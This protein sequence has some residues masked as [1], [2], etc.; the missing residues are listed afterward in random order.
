MEEKKKEKNC[1]L[2][3]EP[4]HDLTPHRVDIYA[5][6][7]FLRKYNPASIRR[8]VVS[9]KCQV[10]GKYQFL[11]ITIEY[12]KTKQNDVQQRTLGIQKAP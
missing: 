6:E 1:K 8:Q 11:V 10:I 12:E 4:G 9:T 2:F 5:S 7:S 3:M